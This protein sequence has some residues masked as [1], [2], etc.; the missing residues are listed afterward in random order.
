MLRFCLLTLRPWR[1]QIWLGLVLMLAQLALTLM[2]IPLAGQ[3]E[4]FF[5]D[6][7]LPRYW[8]LLGLICLAFAGRHLLEYGLQLNLGW[9]SSA[10]AN[11]VRR[12]AFARLLQADWLSLQTID[13][14][15]ALASLSDDLDKLQQGLLAL[16]LRLIP[17]GLV[18]SALSACLLL[19]S[20]PLSLLLLTAVPSAALLIR[21]IGR[22]LAQH[23]GA[24]QSQLA[25][26]FQELNETLQQRLLIR[27]YRQESAQLQRLD[28]TQQAWLSARLR[29]LAY[30]AGERPLLGTLQVCALAG[31]LAFSGW[32]VHAG[33]LSGAELLAYATALGL[34]IDP[35]LWAAEA[36]GQIQLARASWRRLERLLNLPIQQR[37]LP[38][39]SASG[40]LELTGICLQHGEH[41]ILSDLSLSLAPGEK[42][43]L[44]GAS[45]VGKSTLLSLIAGLEVPQAGEIQLPAA[46]LAEPDALLLVPQRAT[47]FKRSLRENLCLDRS[48]EAAELAEVLI[49]CGLDQRIAQ[50]PAGLDTP[51]GALGGW[52]SGGERQRLA[53]AR[54]LLRRPRCLLLDE[55]TSEMDP[56]LEAGIFARLRQARPELSWLA[57]SHR[58]ETLQSL[59]RVW[60]LVKGRLEEETACQ[61]SVGNRP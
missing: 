53:L 38:R 22:A 28:Q 56:A 32:L 51:A 13:P 39:A 9:L 35:S 23:G 31:L 59:D 10:W 40:R 60:H 20:W 24:Q 57:V 48:V 4:S 41:A 29:T 5:H 30:Q 2:L 14:D 52:L 33:L 26:L 54:A 1:A 19:I 46:W 34:A 18:L 47:L 6:L 21:W 61:S 8:G 37:S 15:D 17:A 44:S 36:W 42:T 12:Q 49:I 55:A 11:S 25:R 43:G 7:D 27:L 50:L 16:L 3:L 58:P 45:G